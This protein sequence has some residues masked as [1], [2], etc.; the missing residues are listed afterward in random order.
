MGMKKKRKQEEEIL[1][2]PLEIE[3][4]LKEDIDE[5][6]DFDAVEDE[7]VEAAVEVED[8]PVEAEEVETPAAGLDR[9]EKTIQ[10]IIKKGQAKGHLTYEEINDDL[11]D[12]AISPER[13]D[14]LLMTL[15]ELG[16]Q[17]L[18][19]SDVPHEGEEEL[20]E[21]DEEFERT[22]EDLD[23]DLTLEDQLEEGEGRR[24]TTG[25]DVPDADG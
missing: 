4:P 23:E 22:D 1:E 18:D 11:P 17:L 14:S 21:S 20:E 24:S 25:A 16:V 12:E 8:A 6:D 10:K 13:L 2:A 15:D 3:A 7:D 19:E 5:I 9:I